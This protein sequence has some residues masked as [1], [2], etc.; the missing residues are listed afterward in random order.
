M[1]SSTFSSKLKK[2]TVLTSTKASTNGTAADNNI[3]TN[4][5]MAEQST[6][7]SNAVVKQGAM[8][9]HEMS[10]MKENNKSGM[11]ARLQN[12][13]NSSNNFKGT[14]ASNRR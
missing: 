9:Y 1:K 7:T 10:R 11:L 8:S 2:P 13:D 3:T 4:Y 5:S 14:T 6:L 12:A